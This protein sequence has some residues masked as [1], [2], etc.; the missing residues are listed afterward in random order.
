VGRNGAVFPEN[1]IRHP[2]IV[3]GGLFIAGLD[4]RDV[5]RRHVGDVR[6]DALTFERVPASK[7]GCERLF[8]AAYCFC[9]GSLS[10]VRQTGCA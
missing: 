3:L 1:P 4:A 5:V 2:E 7:C 10:E 6:F 8:A 9:T